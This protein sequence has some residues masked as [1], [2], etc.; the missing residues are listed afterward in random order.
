MA[1][2]TVGTNS[3]ITT[4]ELTA[5]ASNRGITITGDASILLIKAMDVI[6]S[7]NYSGYKTDS[8]Q[9]L[10]FPRY[11]ISEAYDNI[12]PTQVKTAQCMLSIAIGEG[13]DFG[14]MDD[15]SAFGS[16]QLGV[17]KVDTSGRGRVPLPPFVV[18]ILSPFMS[19]GLRLARG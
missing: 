17:I 7:K 5:Y 18:D 16:V 14:A 1:T 8:A 12:V 2:I 10:S 11:G 15:L 19:G 3:Y 6:E 4:E 13:A 9:A